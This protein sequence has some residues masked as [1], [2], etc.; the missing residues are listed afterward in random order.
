MDEMIGGKCKRCGNM[1]VYAKLFR[2]GS[3]G[4]VCEPGYRQLTD[5]NKKMPEGN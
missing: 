4:M 3:G 2:Y 1:T 5:D